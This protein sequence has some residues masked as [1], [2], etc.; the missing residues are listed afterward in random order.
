M[1]FLNDLF[2][3]LVFLGWGVAGVYLA[4]RQRSVWEMFLALCFTAFGLLMGAYTFH[5][6]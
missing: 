2:G 3:L 5:L 4:W 1:T 6:W